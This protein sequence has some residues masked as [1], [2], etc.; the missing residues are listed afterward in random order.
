LTQA[1]TQAASP[2]DA[3]RAGLKPSLAAAPSSGSKSPAPELDRSV[4]GL[5]E[6]LS[7]ENWPRDLVPHQQ[8]DPDPPHLQD[9]TIAV[10]PDTQYY[11]SCREKH[12]AAQT[13]YVAHLARSRRIVASVF[14]GDLTEHNEAEE[15]R[16][17]G[18]ALSLLPRDVPIVLATGNHDYGLGGTSNVRSTLFNDFLKATPKTQSVMVE[19]M[20]PNH[21]ENVFYRID[22]PTL[23]LAILVLEWSPRDKAVAWAKNMLLKYPDERLIFVTHAYLYYDDTRYDWERYGQDQR[24]NPLAYGTAKRDPD[25]PPGGDNVHP[26]GAWDGER[27]WQGL[28]S[29]YAGLFLTLNGH[30]LGDGSGLSS[31]RGQHG[32]LVHQV[33]VNYQVL[34]EGG[35]GYLRLLEFAHDGTTLRMKTYSPSLDRY[36]TASD[37]LY[38][39]TLEPPLRPALTV[40]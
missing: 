40:Q 23:S 15:W 2:T 18:E 12:F 37:Q 20:E 22:D 6:D 29:D 34:E 31:V 25:R 26:D 7:R 4:C 3:Q 14:L 13:K 30:V 9:I 16:F 17:V 21:L 5:P 28:L 19:Q 1:C 36:A 11:T 8:L 38:T 33:L 39:L 10:L 24:W 27:L 32:N 35:L